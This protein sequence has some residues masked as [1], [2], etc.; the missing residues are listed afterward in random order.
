M[1]GSNKK[2]AEVEAEAI[3]QWLG[4]VLHGT[5]LG[6][7]SGNPSGPPSLPGM[8]LITEQGVILEHCWYGP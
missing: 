5:N 1:A 6:L 2:N 4:F 7:V 3:V 8:I